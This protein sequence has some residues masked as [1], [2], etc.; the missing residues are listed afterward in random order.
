MIPLYT[1]VRLKRGIPPAVTGI[2]MGTFFLHLAVEACIQFHWVEPDFRS[3]WMTF[4][5]SNPNPFERVLSLFSH[6]SYMHWLGNMIYLWIFGS[7]LEDRLGWAKFLLLFLFCGFTADLL[8]WGLVLLAVHSLGMEMPHIRSLGA[9]GA[10]AGIMGLS[11]FR[12]YKARVMLL[13]MLWTPLLWLR[14]SIPVWIFCLYS[15]LSD[16]VGIFRMDNVAHLAHIGGFLGGLAAGRFLKL[17]KQSDE[18]I[19]ME[20]GLLYRDSKMFKD[21]AMDFEKALAL[22]PQNALAHQELGFCCWGLHNPTKTAD[23]QLAKAKAQF[24]EA[25]DLYL[26][27]DQGVEAVLLYERLMKILT[28]QDF[29]EKFPLLLKAHQKEA[30]LS[31]AILTSD[32]AERRAMLEENFRGQYHR[33]SYQAARETLREL[34]VRRH[35]SDME[36][37]LLEAAGD[38]C[39]RVNDT[40]GA[41]DFFE[42]LA[43]KGDERQTVRALTVLARSWLQ[44]PKQLQLRVLFN[45]AEERLYK[46]RAYDEWLQLEAQIKGLLG[47]DDGGTKRSNLEEKLQAQAGQ[48]DFS[49]ARSTLKELTAISV[50]NEMEAG[51]LDMAG[52]VCLKVNDLPGAELYFEALSK[53][54]DER[55][56]L[57]ALSVLTHAWLQTPKQV[58]LKFLLIRAE[59]RLPGLK[60]SDEWLELGKKIKGSPTGNPEG[61]VS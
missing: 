48:G 41:E 11:M 16:I 27:G 55:Q 49:G 59:D 9:S 22:N 56:T 7:I 17:K 43:R 6:A 39:V 19:Y 44:T 51:V 21:A 29:P 34:C 37:S 40:A 50:L 57:R 24:T 31:T 30:G 42:P 5:L 12:F 13:F 54:G 58:Q 4:D 52:E 60:A 3:R 20:R 1:D 14:R 8:Y 36:P 45:R 38:V 18:E 35:I 32:P 61:P 33:G 2:I 47:G 53:K 10:I 15:V 28:P 23:P 26:K 46:V 25:L